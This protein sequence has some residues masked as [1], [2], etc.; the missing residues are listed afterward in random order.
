MPNHQNKRKSRVD[1]HRR[2]LLSGI[3]NQLSELASKL[4]NLDL[5]RADQDKFRQVIAGA[6]IYYFEMFKP[7]EGHDELPLVDPREEGW[8][9]GG[10]DEVCL[11]HLIAAA[12]DAVERC[13]Q[14]QEESEFNVPRPP[15]SPGQVCDF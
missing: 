5:T 7:R 1:R 12:I 10:L 4:R 8:C 15:L 6:L 3:L 13:G 14:R 9:D 11:D 2:S